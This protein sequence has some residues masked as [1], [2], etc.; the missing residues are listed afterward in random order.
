MSD[1]GESFESK[2]FEL[3]LT[4]AISRRRKC[5]DCSIFEY[6][7]GGCNNIALVY[8]GVENN[9]HEMCV[10]LRE[11]YKHIEKSILEAMHNEDSN[12]NPM[13][14]KIFDRYRKSK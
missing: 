13:V 1:I 7:A 2:G 11:I 3:L 9:N 8:G 12:I 14:K 6:C 5:K 4:Q 10:A